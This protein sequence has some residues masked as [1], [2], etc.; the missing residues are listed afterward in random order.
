MSHTPNAP[1]LALLNKCAPPARVIAHAVPTRILRV[2]Q[3]DEAGMTFRVEQLVEHGGFGGPE[4]KGEWKT[5]STHGGKVS[6]Q[7][8]GIAFEALWKAQKDLVYKLRKQM[9]ARMPNINHREPA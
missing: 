6:G 3:M 9:V 7:T 8:L 1:L 5:I 2:T 4:P